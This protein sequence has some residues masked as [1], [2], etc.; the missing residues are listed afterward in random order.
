MDFGKLFNGDDDSDENNDDY[1]TEET[2]EGKK[3]VSKAVNSGE[4]YAVA[5]RNGR[6]IG[7]IV[8]TGF[9][10]A[11]KV[12]FDKY[13]D[14]EEDSELSITNVAT[15]GYERFFVGDVVD[16][17]PPEPWEHGAGDRFSRFEHT[18]PE[19]VDDALADFRKRTENVE[20]LGDLLNQVEAVAD[21]L[22]DDDFECPVCGL[23]HGHAIDKHDVR[24]VYGVTD[25]FAQAV[26]SFNAVCHCGLH[27]LAELVDSYD[28]E[29]PMFEDGEPSDAKVE[30]IKN[31]AKN[32][33][34][35]DSVHRKL[36]AR[37]NR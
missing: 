2:D 9:R 30:S 21:G 1:T 25:I 15:G 17:T 19:A 33:P 34:V 35:P 27:E 8:A 14:I 12:A 18:D 32:A 24:E 16:L 28:G 3:F 36:D 23:S 37:F 20:G 7:T 6:Y 31:A 29:V 11:V 26:M 10:D 13:V 5:F 4:E 22:T